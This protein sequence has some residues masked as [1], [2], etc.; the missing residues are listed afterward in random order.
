ME[1][2][3]DVEGNALIIYKKSDTTDATDTTAAITNSQKDEVDR[4][5]L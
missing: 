3:K 4:Q 2:Y 5:N 1:K